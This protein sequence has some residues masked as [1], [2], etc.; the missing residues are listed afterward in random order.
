MRNFDIEYMGKS[1]VLNINEQN[2][3]KAKRIA[4]SFLKT[5]SPENYYSKM[6]TKQYKIKTDYLE[7]L[8]SDSDDENPNPAWGNVLSKESARKILKDVEAVNENMASQNLISRN[9]LKPLWYGIFPLYRMVVDI[10]SIFYG[11]VEILAMILSFLKN[12]LENGVREKKLTQTKYHKEKLSKEDE[13]YIK[14]ESKK[15]VYY[16]LLLGTVSF[17]LLYIIKSISLTS[18]SKFLL[19]SLSIL[20]I[21]ILIVDI[22]RGLIHGK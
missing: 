19:M 5:L 3:N 10:K 9:K 8:S 18:L 4:K 15:R 12:I 11:V 21:L 14:A 1:Y 2:P 22:F 13:D 6:L 7:Y 17:I 16:R 20:L